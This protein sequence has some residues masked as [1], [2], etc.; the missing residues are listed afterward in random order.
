MAS[1]HKSPRLCQAP[2]LVFKAPPVSADPPAAPV[3]DVI[4][5][6]L[7]GGGISLLAGAPNIGKTALLSTMVRDIRDGHLI[8][9]HQPR[10][11]PAIGMINA[12]RGWAKGAGHWFAQSGYPEILHYSLADDPS[13]D[14][15][16]LRRRFDRTDLLASF[17][18]R[19]ELPEDSLLVVDPLS[20][21]LG[22]N[23]LDYDACM[24]ACHE[25][26]SYLRRR[27]Y[28]LLA[29][30]HSGKMKNDKRER[31]V[32]TSD[33][34]LGSTAIPGFTDAVLHLASPEELG[35]S[36]YQLVWHP[37]CAKAE[38]YLLDRDARGLFLEW[39]GADAATLA[40]VLALFPAEAAEITLATLVEYAQA[41]PLSKATVKRALEA[42]TEQ[43][44]IERS[45]HGKYRRI[46]IL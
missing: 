33:Q 22:G 12:D 18:D 5:D 37:H 25:I 41:L 15:H 42:L 8:F 45:G 34:I 35:K 38:T 24:V 7:P 43:G 19:L 3:A 23:L 27:R 11:V 39:T 10:H 44:S 21:F 28:T 40:R 20:L 29:T 36:Y 31:Y 9:G 4:P 26:R 6:R 46:L 16:R 13:F 17:A 30:A 2:T 1:L 14:P 32:R